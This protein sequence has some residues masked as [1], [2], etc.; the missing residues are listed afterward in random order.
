[1]EARHPGGTSP[2]GEKSAINSPMDTDN[3]NQLFNNEL[4]DH[5]LED[6]IKNIAKQVYELHQRTRRNL[7]SI[8]QITQDQVDKNPTM[9]RIAILEEP[10]TAQNLSA[11]IAALQ[12]SMPVVFSSNKTA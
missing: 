1:M 7:E 11:V 6:I 9:L 5:N 2:S 12:I 3:I 10:L 4:D 8:T